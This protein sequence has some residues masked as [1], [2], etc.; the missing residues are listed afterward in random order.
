[1]KKAQVAV[2]NIHKETGMIFTC[3]IST[4]SKVIVPTQ[5]QVTDPWMLRVLVGFPRGQLGH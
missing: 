1:M 4:D 3:Q 2:R 5:G